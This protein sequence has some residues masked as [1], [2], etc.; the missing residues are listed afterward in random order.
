V[1]PSRG[2]SPAFGKGGG[3][4][5]GGEL[6]IEK[7]T[8]GAGGGDLEIKAGLASLVADNMLRTSG[9]DAGTEAGVGIV[10]KIPL[11]SASGA[12]HGVIRP[13]CL[14]L[15]RGCDSLAGEVVTGCAVATPSW[16]DLSKEDELE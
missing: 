7:S 11:M 10:D 3:C 13:C 1:Q 8:E 14:L 4:G 5:D 15:F 9:V 2:R 12:T 16:E 6:W